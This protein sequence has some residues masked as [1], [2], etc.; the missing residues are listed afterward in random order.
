MVLTCDESTLLRWTVQEQAVNEFKSEQLMNQSRG[1]PFPSQ[2]ISD[3]P[4]DR[5]LV[6]VGPRQTAFTQQCLLEILAESVSIPDA[7][8]RELVPA[9]KQ[10]IELEAL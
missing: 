2:V 1:V 6:Q 9:Q 3:R 8:L 7:K 5:R 4:S 10:P